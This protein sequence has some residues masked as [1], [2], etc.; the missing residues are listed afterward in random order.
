MISEGFIP[1]LRAIRDRPSWKKPLTENEALIDLLFDTTFK[2]RK[3]EG[4]LLMPGQALVKKKQ[5]AKKWGWSR[6][7][8]NRFFKRLAQE[9][10]ELWAIEEEVVSVS[11]YNPHERPRTIG[12]RITFVYWDRFGK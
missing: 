11:S 2:K 8:V 1:L 12:T 5:L 6:E 7:R 9:R 3:V 4:V 10:G